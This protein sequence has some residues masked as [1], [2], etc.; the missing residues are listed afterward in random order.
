MYYELNFRLIE[1]QRKYQEPRPGAVGKGTEVLLSVFLLFE[2]GEV[3]KV[4]ECTPMQE[5]C[6]TATPLCIP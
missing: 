3:N 2:V 6:V 4:Y 1:T 5:P